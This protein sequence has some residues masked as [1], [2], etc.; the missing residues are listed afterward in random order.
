MK[1]A[2]DWFEDRTGLISLG[3]KALEEHI[4]GGP[5]WAYVFGSGLL[6]TFTLQAVTGILLAFYFSPSAT[7]AWGSVWF[8]QHELTLGW[9]LRGMHHF[10]SSVMVVLCVCHMLQVFLYGAH[11]APREVNW[12]TGVL[13]LAMVLGFSLTGYL[14]PWD[15]KGYWA[16]KVA[17]SIAG[18]L[19]LIGEPIQ[20]FLQGGSDYGNLT[21]TRFYA[22]HVFVLPI[23]TVGFIAV[24]VMLFRRHG[25]TPPPAMSDRELEEKAGWFWPVQVLKDAAFGLA[26][27][28]LLMALALWLGAPL[29][30]PADP[31][32][33]YDARPEWYYLFLFQLLKYFEGPLVLIG[34]VVLPG[35]AGL[36]LLLLPFLD[37]G[38]DRR[39]SA[40][41]L[42]AGLF[43]AGLASVVAMTAI[44]MNEDANNE[45]FQK[46][47]AQA[48][49]DAADAVRYAGIDGYGIDAA[50]RVVLFEGKK[51]FRREACDQCHEAVEPGAEEKGPSL[52]GY[53]SRPWIER[54][55]RDPNTS[56]HFGNT[57]LA[58]EMP[59]TE[60]SDEEIAQLVEFVASRSKNAYDPPIDEALAAKGAALFE[61][62]D[63]SG[64]HSIDG[65]G[66]MGPDLLDY[67]SAA[68]LSRMLKAPTHEL[69]YGDAGDGM[70]PFDH[71]G[72]QEEQLLIGWL[73]HLRHETDTEPGAP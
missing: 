66:N 32:S 51:I 26:I 41:K 36:F 6:I 5:R 55:L 12:I 27:V 70:P 44:A 49:V 29:D 35:I 3:K 19:P 13:L 16:T 23:L 4:P 57:K 20:T 69:M 1:R 73:L 61:D 68:W 42:W 14:L 25:V 28:A 54:F 31:A 63:C 38:P 56:K 8:I 72:E 67:G 34:T 58:D 17:T 53:L 65:S 40:R 37:R 62:G 60:A 46:A 59:A 45:H 9:L 52:A 64:C 15:Q 71:L 33:E 24:H 43:F 50:G 7:D 39:L 10:G 48:K 2:L 22:L 47:V 18:G 11:K 30:S 21:L